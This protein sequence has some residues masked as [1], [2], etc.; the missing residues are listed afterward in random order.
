MGKFL[1]WGATSKMQ[2]PRRRKPLELSLERRKRPFRPHRT[3]SKPSPSNR[4]RRTSHRTTKRP[5]RPT[6]QAPNPKL[7]LK[8]TT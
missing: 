2:T 3:I 7:A 1:L 8:L 5:E 4:L 6:N